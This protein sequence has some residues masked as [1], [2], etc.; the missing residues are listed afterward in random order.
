MMPHGTWRWR[1][2]SAWWALAT[3]VVVAFA[4]SAGAEVPERKPYLLLVS[5]YTPPLAGVTD[6]HLAF[7]RESAYDGVAIPIADAYD[8]APLAEI[9]QI[10]AQLDSARVK[11]QMDLWPWFYL[12][13]F[14]G[15]PE[16]RHDAGV[17]VGD[18][19]ADYFG[20]IRALDLDDRAGALSDMIGLWRLS[21]RSARASGSPGVVVDLELYNDYRCSNVTFVAKQ[22]GETVEQVRERL[23]EVGRDMGRIVAEEYPDAVLL[24]LFTRLGETGSGGTAPTESE[25]SEGLLGFL[26]EKSV[27]ARL[28]DGGEISPGYYNPGVDALRRRIAER[29]EHLRP[30]L[31]KYAGRFGLAGTIAPYHDSKILE[32]WIADAAG[33]DPPFRSLEDF[34]PMLRELFARYRY[35]WIYAAKAAKANP[36]DPA[37]APQ[38]NRI[39]AEVIEEV[40][41]SHVPVG[42]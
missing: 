20:R 5:F 14:V 28:L 13:R 38:Y 4:V 41:G 31:E 6:E 35:V 18:R 40:S 1:R 11:S 25:L 33:T 3:G 2:C 21:L 16:G 34:R 30:F 7:I 26:A 37:I 36:Y 17:Q 32:S 12:N 24:A 27:P 8:A 15:R 19:A 22:R 29:E 23:R 42:R 39:F 9:V 10:A